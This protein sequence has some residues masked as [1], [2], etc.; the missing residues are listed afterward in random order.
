MILV[1]G[2]CVSVFAAL[3]QHQEVIGNRALWQV[4]MF[5]APLFSFLDG[6]RTPPRACSPY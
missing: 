1:V 6:L 5:N 3:F 2:V 4:F